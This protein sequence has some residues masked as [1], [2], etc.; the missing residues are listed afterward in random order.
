MSKLSMFMG[1]E[2]A[3]SPSS[4]Y[5]SGFMITDAT[6]YRHS[7]VCGA[8]TLPNIYWTECNFNM[9]LNDYWAGIVKNMIAERPQ[10]V[11]VT[12]Q[13][14]RHYLFNSHFI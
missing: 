11:Y 12:V 3:S 14:E 7:L 5:H 9:Y 8:E 2:I 6:G 13:T 10:F 1:R 4:L